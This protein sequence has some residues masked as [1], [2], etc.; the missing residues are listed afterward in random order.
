MGSFGQPR[1][2]RLQNYFDH[3]VRVFQNIVVPEPDYPPSRCLERA[4]PFGIFRVV[5]MLAAIHFDDELRLTANE[6]GDRLADYELSCESRTI[7]S[8]RMPK[9]P[10][11]VCRFVAQFA[12]AFLQQ[13][14]YVRH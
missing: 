12:C 4:S 6:I 2:D 5:V 3:S 10:L 11:R 8:K 13:S 9:L 14:G 7:T 1:R